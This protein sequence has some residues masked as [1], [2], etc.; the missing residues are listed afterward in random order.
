MAQ[1]CDS[2]L[3]LFSTLERLDIRDG[4]LPGPHWQDDMENNQW[5]ELFH[6]FTALK[7][8]YLDNKFAPLVAPALQEPVGER[9]TEILS[10]LQ[11][12]LAADLQPWGSVRKALGQFA[13][14]RGLSGRPVVVFSWDGRS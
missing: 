5:L 7:D 12:I 9:G 2:I 8:L 4:G 11:N 14:A 6:P 3:P 13:A 10:G 1:V